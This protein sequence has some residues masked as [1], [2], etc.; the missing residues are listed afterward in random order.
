MAGRLLGDGGAP[1]KHQVSQARSQRHGDHDPAVVGHE[2]EPVLFQP[3]VLFDRHEDA[4]D[5]H[6]HKSVK[7]LDAVQ[8]RLGDVGPP[9]DLVPVLACCAQAQKGG[10]LSS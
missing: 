9:R 4:A 10:C 1:A 8:H 7:V 3:D 2:D 5:S 6:D